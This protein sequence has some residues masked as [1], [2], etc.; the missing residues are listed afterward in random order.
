VPILGAITRLIKI[1][2]KYVNACIT[3]IIMLIP[4]LLNILFDQ[5]DYLTLVG[6]ASLNKR[7]T[8]YATKYSLLAYF[9]IAKNMKIIKHLIINGTIEP[10][11]SYIGPVMDNGRCMRHHHNHNQ[12][13]QKQIE[14]VKLLTSNGISCDEL[15]CE[16]ASSGHLQSV[17]YL[18]G[19]CTNHMMDVALAYAAYYGYLDIIKF[20]IGVG[21]NI[22]T[23]DSAP[24]RWSAFN[25]KLCVV[26]Y[27]VGI[28]AKLENRNIFFDSWSETYEYLESIGENVS[29]KMYS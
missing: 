26:E 11:C 8:R 13:E 23:N 27:L 18:T 10:I 21:A 7:K 19:F 17:K 24:L 16:C 14:L 4:D 1:E 20:L 22:H 9:H 12:P 6:L 29:V 28:G 25:D 2:I 3:I 5:S 15:I